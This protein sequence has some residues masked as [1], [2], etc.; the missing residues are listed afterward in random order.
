MEVRIKETGKVEFLEIVDHK[1]GQNYVADFIGNA[2]GFVNGNF[3]KNADGEIE[4][5]QENF[6]WWKEVITENQ[7]LEAHIADL[8]EKFGYDA[9]QE[10]LCSA[11][12]SGDLEDHAARVWQM[13]EE[14]FGEAENERKD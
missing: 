10:I 14:E 9:V 1:T 7:A 6:D 12:V 2:G 8:E 5:T 3:Y 11:N 13:L 4:T